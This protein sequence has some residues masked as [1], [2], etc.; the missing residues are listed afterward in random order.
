MIETILYA[1]TESVSDIMQDGITRI[2]CECI[3]KYQNS[4]PRISLTFKKLYNAKQSGAICIN[5]MSYNDMLAFKN[6]I[7]N[8]IDEALSNAYK[9]SKI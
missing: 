4:E 2:A 1:D 5:Q 7:N 3:V 9:L 6:Q 8:V